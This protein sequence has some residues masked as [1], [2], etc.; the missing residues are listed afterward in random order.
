MTVFGSTDRPLVVTNANDSQRSVLREALKRLFVGI[1]GLLVLSFAVQRL[2]ELIVPTN[3]PPP[4]PGMSASHAVSL[5]PG[6]IVFVVGLLFIA[7]I[8]IRWAVRTAQ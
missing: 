4:P 2:S 3:H 8:V 1:G 5:P 6:L 7:V